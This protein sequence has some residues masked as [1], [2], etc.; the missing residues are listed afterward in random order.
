V[1]AE[2]TFFGDTGKTS[3]I[4]LETTTILRCSEGCNII[5]KCTECGNTFLK[6][7]L[8]VGEVVSCPVC[9]ANYKAV[10]KDGK[11]HLDDLVFEEQDLGEL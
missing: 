3:R 5:L 8:V 2:G 11:L 10:I 7:R 9:E 4:G 6:E 1:K